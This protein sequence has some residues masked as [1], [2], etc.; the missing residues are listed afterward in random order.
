MNRALRR[1]DNPRPSFEKLPNTVYRF[2]Q[3]D[4]IARPVNHL[5]Y[6]TRALCRLIYGPLGILAAYRSGAVPILA[7]RL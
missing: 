3:A 7:T 2:D 4:K 6:N 5:F 1:T